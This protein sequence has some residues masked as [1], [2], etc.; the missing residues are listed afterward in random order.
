WL[1]AGGGWLPLLMRPVSN[2]SGIEATVGSGMQAVGLGLTVVGFV[3]LGRSFGVVAADRGLKVGGP[4]R[5]VRH[6]I[7]A[8]HLFTLVGFL[9]AN[10]SEWNIALGAIVT[11]CQLLRLRAEER[12]LTETGDYDGYR[13]RVRWRLVPFIY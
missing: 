7:Y 4:Y 1:V 9:I 8:A 13:A 11:V 6:P 10:P 3:Y 5:V 2:S 12:V